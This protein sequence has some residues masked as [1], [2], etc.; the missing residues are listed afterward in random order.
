[1]KRHTRDREEIYAKYKSDK[2]PLSKIYKEFI[3]LEENNLIKK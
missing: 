2:G 3:K 1:M